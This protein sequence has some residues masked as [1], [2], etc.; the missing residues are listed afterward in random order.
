MSADFKENI[1]RKGKPKNS[2][3]GIIAIQIGAKRQ[4]GW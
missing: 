2:V 4:I 3:N 1:L